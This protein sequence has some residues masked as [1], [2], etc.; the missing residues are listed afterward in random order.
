MRKDPRSCQACKC[1]LKGF[2][3]VFRR[4]RACKISSLL[5]SLLT[6][7]VV[8]KIYSPEELLRIAGTAHNR[9]LGSTLTTLTQLLIF[10][11]SLPGRILLAYMFSAS[12]AGSY[13]RKHRV[14][15]AQELGIAL[16]V[17]IVMIIVMLAL[18]L[19]AGEIAHQCIP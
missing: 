19:G 15:E 5:S 10:G 2:V 6:S 13:L 14:I 4:V 1:I 3:F 18:D 8:F 16:I 9:C 17:S 12:L 7:G 11:Q